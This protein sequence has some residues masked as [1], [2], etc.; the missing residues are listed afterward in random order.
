MR[1]ERNVGG[2]DGTA[3][4]VPGPLVVLVGVAGL[5]GVAPGGVAVGALVLGAV[6]AVTG[7]SR[8]CNLDR[9]LGLDTSGR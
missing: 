1:M 6:F 4:L 5:L 2:L 3:R 8:K 7:L 9:P